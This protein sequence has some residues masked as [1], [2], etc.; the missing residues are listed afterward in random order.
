MPLSLIHIKI[1]TVSCLVCLRRK[2]QSVTTS[3][4]DSQILMGRQRTRILHVCGYWI[5]IPR[6]HLMS[7]VRFGSGRFG[8]FLSRGGGTAGELLSSNPVVDCRDRFIW[9]K[10]WWT[11]YR[12]TVHL[13]YIRRLKVWSN[14]SINRCHMD[15]HIT[16]VGSD[17]LTKLKHIIAVTGSH[18]FRLS[19]H[20]VVGGSL[21]F[22]FSNCVLNLVTIFSCYL[23]MS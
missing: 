13:Y 5:E 14:I 4:H 3:V 2:N 8:G 6:K 21:S 9:R 7:R 18:I 15:R 1:Q 12:P 22:S 23:T 10:R 16:D 20:L 19:L 17:V 11:L